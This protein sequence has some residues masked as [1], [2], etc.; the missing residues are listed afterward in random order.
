MPRVFVSH[1]SKDRA[2][3]EREILPLLQGQ[4]ID[5]WFS[6]D[7]IS[8]A[9]EW[10][11]N[12]RAGLQSCD[13]FLVVLSPRSAASQWVKAE[14]QWAFDNRNGRIVPVL[15]DTYCPSDFHLLLGSIQH[16]DYSQN[17][18]EGRR[19]LLQIWGIE[20]EHE[21]SPH[22]LRLVQSPTGLQGSIFPVKGRMILG[23]SPAAA[24]QP[25]CTMIR[26]DDRCLSQRHAEITLREDGTVLLVDLTSHNG[27]FVNGKLV[28]APLVLRD[29]DEIRLGMNLLV[30][31]RFAD[32]GGSL[33]MNTEDVLGQQPV[34][35]DG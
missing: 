24:G 10:E 1:S 27:T 7:D 33:G 25:E 12:I 14:L 34:A 3:V 35:R 23:R 21:R 28:R 4:G 26:I 18:E 8:S 31:R 5:T 2:F 17:P 6:T 15:I 32:G 9:S 19:R 11:R 13:W 22:E 20:Y 29:G 30:Y 16:I